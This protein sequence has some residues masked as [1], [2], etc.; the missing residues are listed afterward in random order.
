M[1]ASLG[2]KAVVFLVALY[3]ADC[4]P[5][6]L[7]NICDPIGGRYRNFVFIKSLLDNGDSFCGKTFLQTPPSAL[8]YPGSPSSF[9]N[10]S[11]ISLSPSVTGNG[12]TF[13]ILPALPEGVSIGTGNGVISGTYSSY[14][15]LAQTYTVKASNSGGSVSYSF[16]LTFSESPL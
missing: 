6:A 3:F 1:E 15:G 13:S 8:R 12:L 4:S 7:E 2:R 11:V 9:A 14:A 16:S 10:G 5:V